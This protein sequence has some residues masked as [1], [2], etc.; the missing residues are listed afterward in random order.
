[1]PFLLDDLVAG[2]GSGRTRMINAVCTSIVFGTR[3]IESADTGSRR[4]S[5]HNN[6]RNNKGAKADRTVIKTLHRVDFNRW[7]GPLRDLGRTSGLEVAI[8]LSV[9][10]CCGCTVGFVSR[11]ERVFMLSYK[12]G[13]KDQQSETWCLATSRYLIVRFRRSAETT[14]SINSQYTPMQRWK[15]YYVALVTVS[16]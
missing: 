5:F 7:R 4:T 13:K 3:G 11:F 10:V 12:T 8:R 6:R 9:P 15:L 14:T 2:G 16:S 1:M